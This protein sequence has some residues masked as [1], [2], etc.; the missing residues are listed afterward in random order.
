MR[1][2]WLRL[3]IEWLEANSKWLPEQ[4]HNF[5]KSATK[6]FFDI[7]MEMLRYEKIVMIDTGFVYKNSEVRHLARVAKGNTHLGLYL[8]LPWGAQDRIFEAM[9]MTLNLISATTCVPKRA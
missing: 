6:G 8:E 3:A 4:Y 9:Y 7:R 1:V 5:V 2:V